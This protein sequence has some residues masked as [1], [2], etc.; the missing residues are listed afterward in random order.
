[1]GKNWL[2]TTYNNGQGA[3][4]SPIAGTQITA[5]FGADGKVTGTDSCN[6]YTASY[7]VSGKSLTVGA[8]VQTGMACP[9]DVTLQAQ[10]Y[11][12]ALQLSQSY[13]VSGN[14]LNIFGSGSQKLLQ[15]VAQ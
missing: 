10:S 13:E 2:L 11:I 4:V 7:T 3:L 14:Q 1:V 9:E 6:T 12:A 15:Y 8:P 5:L